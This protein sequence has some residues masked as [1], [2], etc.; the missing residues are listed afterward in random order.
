[1]RQSH[2]HA[3]SEVWLAGQGWRRID[4]TAAVAPERIERGIEA[5][6]AGSDLLPGAFMRDSPLL[7]KMGMIWD[8]VNAEWNDWVVQFDRALQNEILLDLGFDDP[9]EAFV[10]TAGLYAVVMLFGW[11]AFEFRPRSPDPAAAAYRRFAN[12]LARR[13]FDL[14]TGEAPRD[15]A[16]RVRRFRPELGL[17]ALAITETYLRLRYGPAPAVSDLK[18]LREQVARFRP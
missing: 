14:E 10:A 16:R 6:F 4:P 18:L 8:N 1:M 3:W 7:W 9:D 15:F 5:S 17:S 11:L 2:A 13:G 12:R